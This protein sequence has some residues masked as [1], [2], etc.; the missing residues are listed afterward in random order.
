VRRGTPFFERT[1]AL[2]GSQFFYEWSSLLVI[3]VFTSVEQEL[4]A[5][6][7]TA[8]VNDMSPLY[9]HQ[10]S[11]TDAERLVDFLVTKDTSSL[12]PGRVLYTPWCTED[13][14]LVN[15]GLVFRLDEDRYWISTDM[16]MQWFRAVA[17][18]I[19]ADVVVTDISDDWGILSLQGPASR[20]VLGR[21]TDEDWSD[22]PFSRIREATIAGARAYVSRQGFTGELGFEL[23]V[24]RQD[25]IPMLDAVLAAGQGPGL[26]L[27]G[28]IAVDIAR[29]EAGLVLVSADY[30]GAGPDFHSVRYVDG[31]PASPYAMGLGYLV[32]LDKVN[33]FIGQ[34]ALAA[35]QANGG[36]GQQLVGLE[37]DWHAVSTLFEAEGRPALVR[38]EV[39]WVPFTVTVGGRGVGR[40]TSVTWSPSAGRLIGFGV[41]D[42][43]VAG[44]DT[45]VDV[46][47]DRDGATG[48][49]PA[50]V[51]A[52]PFVTRTR[53]VA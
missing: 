6:R 27:A 47:W 8:T 42:D 24:D 23:W 13:G 2:A 51:T 44:S 15:D 19:A 40:A 22:L 26:Q 52:L 9:K 21:A 33:G 18:Q 35:E 4:R 37:L 30:S 36:P 12:H 20:D 14:L 17:D 31:Y 10:I 34:K 7:E 38:A 45:P 28:S 1:S 3:D 46:A 5:M 29:V 50:H 32:D 53:A 39:S 43:E 11:G 48:T 16:S 25:A 41:L 49:V